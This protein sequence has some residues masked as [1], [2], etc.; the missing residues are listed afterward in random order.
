M[1]FYKVLSVFDPSQRRTGCE[2]WPSVGL[3]LRRGLG[4]L[5]NANTPDDGAR[6]NFVRRISWQ[7]ESRNAPGLGRVP[8][9]M[10]AEI[11]SCKTIDVIFKPRT[12]GCIVKTHIEA[13]SFIPIHLRTSWTI[14]L[15]F[16][17]SPVSPESGTEMGGPSSTVSE[18]TCCLVVITEMS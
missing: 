8:I 9:K 6:E 4:D 1:L 14:I 15:S 18:V 11:T 2:R 17:L 3:T 16:P 5:N 12:P 7:S 13:M 10:L